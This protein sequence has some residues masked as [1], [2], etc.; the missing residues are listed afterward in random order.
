MVIYS[1]C[2]RTL[3]K[4]DTISASDLYGIYNGSSCESHTN[5]PLILYLLLNSKLFGTQALLQIQKNISDAQKHLKK[6]IYKGNR[7]I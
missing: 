4:Y 3:I 7:L 5:R 1:R 6:I 2:I